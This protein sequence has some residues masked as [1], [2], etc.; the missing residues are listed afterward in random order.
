MIDSLLN[1]IPKGGGQEGERQGRG[2][3]KRVAP[4]ARTLWQALGLAGCD[5][6]QSRR[7]C[8]LC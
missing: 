3:S 6:M 8:G 7:C 1:E 2:R 5:A 4:P